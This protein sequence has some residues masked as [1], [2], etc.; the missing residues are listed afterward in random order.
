MTHETIKWKLFPFSLLGRA[1]QWY[2]HIVGGVHANWDEFRDKFYLAFF[3]LSQNAALRI[4]IHTFQQKEKET[5]G[6]AWARFTTVIN[7]GPIL[8][9]PNHFHPTS[10]PP[11]S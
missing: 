1:K 3:P 4:E 6:A 2:I 8:S 10:L 9:L 11:W 7:A 5:L